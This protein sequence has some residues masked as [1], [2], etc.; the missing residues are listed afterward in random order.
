MFPLE[1]VRQLSLSDV[2]GEMWIDWF[3][4]IRLMLEQHLEITTYYYSF[5]V[6]FC[7]FM[8]RCSFLI[9]VCI[10]MICKFG[11]RDVLEIRLK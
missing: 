11:V 6:R 5:L 4:W 7:I 3:A 2:F 8:S 9:C 1:N 10:V